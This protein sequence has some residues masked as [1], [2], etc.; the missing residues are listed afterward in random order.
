MHIS[1]N[2]AIAHVRSPSNHEPR[3]NRVADRNPGTRRARR[4]ERLSRCGEAATRTWTVAQRFVSRLVYTTCYTAAYGLIFPSV[5]LARSV[6]RNNAACRGLKDGLHAACQKVE[7]LFQG[8][9]ESSTDLAG[10]AL[11]PQ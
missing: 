4:P 3:S 5:L 10:P 8:E 2:E 11:A 9:I 7:M 1:F 6:P